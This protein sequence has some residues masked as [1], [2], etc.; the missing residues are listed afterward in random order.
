[1]EPR[2]TQMGVAFAVNPSSEGGIY[3]AQAFGRPK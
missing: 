1:M 2:F 3:W